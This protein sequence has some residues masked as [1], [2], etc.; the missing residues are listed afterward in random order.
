[1]PLGLS[2]IQNGKIPTFIDGEVRGKIFSTE[3][4]SDPCIL[5]LREGF[6][7]VG[8]YQVSLSF[9]YRSKEMLTEYFNTLAHLSP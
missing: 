8:I 9:V 1:M 5:A 3:E 4:T 7:K 2:I 6:K